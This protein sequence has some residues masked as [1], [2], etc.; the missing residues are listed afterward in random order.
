VTEGQNQLR[1]GGKV[2]VPAK[3]TGSQTPRAAP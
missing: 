1:E 2:S 3:A